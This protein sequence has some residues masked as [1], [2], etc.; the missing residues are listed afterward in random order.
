MLRE[1]VVVLPDIR[2][3]HNTGSFFRTSDAFGVSK[4][5]L[6]G[7]T[8]TPPHPHLVKVSL[9]AEDS[10]PWEYVEQ[11][12]DVVSGLRAEG[13]TC[14]GVEQTEQSVELSGENLPDKVAVFFGNEVA[15]LSPEIIEKMDVCMEIPML[16]KKESL[17]VSVTGGIVLYA[18]TSGTKS[19]KMIQ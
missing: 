15:G 18:L 14:V 8:A 2:S 1:L 12:S 19:I 10:V 6:C 7:I 4:I 3:T 9:G 13:Y 16:G 17:N 5:Y 11:V